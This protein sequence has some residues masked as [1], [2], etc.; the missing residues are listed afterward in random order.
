MPQRSIILRTQTPHLEYRSRFVAKSV[1]HRKAVVILYAITLSLAGYAGHGRSVAAPQQSGPL[2]SAQESTSTT[3]LD[4]KDG[5]PLALQ[6][7][8]PVPMLKAKQT[9]LTQSKFSVVD[10]H[11][12][13][14]YRF[15]GSEEKLDDFVKLMDRNNIAK[16]VSLDG[17]LGD[18]FVEH[19]A[20]LAKYP[21]R[22]AIF[23][24]IDWMGDGKKDEPATWDCHRPDFSRRIVKALNEAHAH[25]A[26]GLKIFKRLGLSYKNP[27]GTL[28]AIDDPRWDP[29]WS[30]CG[31]LGIPVIIHTADPAAFFLPVDKQN[32]RWEELSRHPDWSFHGPQFPTRE[33]LLAARN[34]VIA[35]HPNTNFIGAHVANNAEDLQ[36]VSNWLAKYPNLYVEFASRISELGRQPYTSREFFLRHADR[37]LFGTD[38]PWPEE[39]LHLYWRFLE[40]FDE[41]FPYSEKPFPPQGLWNIHGIGLPD[42]VLKKV[43]SENARRIIPGLNL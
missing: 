3:P 28:I 27:D 17:T 20:F 8:R 39:R 35:R 21:G 13:F 7:F 18:R 25:G 37:I 2:P 22:F 41:N 1:R 4:G 23:A 38:G 15:K 26:C 11:S 42:N 29:I 40:T 16:C 14:G 32:E 19:K 10:V 31:Q 33:Q 6:E 12:H 5:R 30:A 43:Y 24:N 36:A 34:R 9:R